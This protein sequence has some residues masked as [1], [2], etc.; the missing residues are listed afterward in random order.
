MDRIMVKEKSLHLLIRFAQSRDL[1]HVPLF[2]GMALLPGNIL[3]GNSMSN[4]LELSW[5]QALPPLILLE[6]LF[7]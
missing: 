6:G 5:Q 3:T 7:T 2:P 4:G 1:K